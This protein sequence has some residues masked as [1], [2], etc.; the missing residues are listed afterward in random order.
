MQH[1]ISTQSL[2]VTTTS[3]KGRGVYTREKISKDTIIEISPIMILSKQ[4]T[5]KIQDTNLSNYIYEYHEQQDALS[6]GYGSL[7]NHSYTPNAYYQFDIDHQILE[8]I[9]LS[10]ILKDEEI[11][12]NYN[13][14]PQDKTELW[15]SVKA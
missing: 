15:F 6:L 3:N 5:I 9:A 4:D 13:G 2:Y 1:E 8:F 12:I 7:Y 10:D 11:T 14:D